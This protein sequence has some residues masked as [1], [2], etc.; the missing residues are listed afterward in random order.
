MSDR[1]EHPPLWL[2]LLFSVFMA[3]LVPIYWIDYGPTNFLYFCDV[4]L[5]MTLISL[6]SNNMLCASAAIIGILIPQAIWIADFLGCAL[7]LPVTGM[8]AYMF[9][10]GLPLFTR[11]L[12]LFH[13]WLPLLLLYLVWRYGY[14]RRAIWVWWPLASA[15][16]VLCYLIAPLPPAPADRPGLPVNINYVHGPSDAAPQDW[17][18]PLTYFLLLLAGMPAFVFWPTHWV[19][20]HCL[21]PRGAPHRDRRASATG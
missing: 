3:I 1:P 14:D 5:F 11:L 13:F 18:P 12:S 6:W 10:A 17:L 16:L 9:D 8:A 21:K 2:K 4:A 20:R 7:N 15:L 19:L